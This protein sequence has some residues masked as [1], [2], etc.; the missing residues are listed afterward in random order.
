MWQRWSGTQKGAEE[1]AARK[2]ALHMKTNGNV[3]HGLKDCL[4]AQALVW[5]SEDF[6]SVSSFVTVLL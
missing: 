2:R 6:G 1:P 5:D 3:L 4:L